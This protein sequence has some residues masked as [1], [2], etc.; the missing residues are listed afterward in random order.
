[1]DTCKPDRGSLLLGDSHLK[2][3]L[4]ADNTTITTGL[5]AGRGTF[6]SSVLL[7]NATF[8][9]DVDFGDATVGGDL[10]MSG[11]SF[12]GKVN[13]GRAEVEGSLLLSNGAIFDS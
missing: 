3:L 13:L 7:R 10:F 11:S 1:V 12:A 2:R 6:D 4:Y 5:R 8:G 9:G